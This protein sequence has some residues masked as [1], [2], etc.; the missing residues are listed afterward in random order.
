LPGAFAINTLFA[1]R[2]CD[3]TGAGDADA[4]GCCAFEKGTD[5]K[6]M[7]KVRQTALCLKLMHI[8]FSV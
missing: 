7:I 8:V 2:I 4:F 3:G 1:V 5:I 6:A